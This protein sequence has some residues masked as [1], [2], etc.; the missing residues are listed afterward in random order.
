MSKAFE[1]DTLKVEPAPL[2]AADLF[3]DAIGDPTEYTRLYTGYIRAFA[4]STLLTQ[5]FEPSAKS[6]EEADRLADEFFHRLDGLY[7]KSLDKCAF[8]IWHMTVVLRRR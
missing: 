4:D 5:L 8:E 7:R 3:E 1:I 2:H 6:A